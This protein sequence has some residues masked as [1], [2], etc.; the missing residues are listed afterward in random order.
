MPSIIP[1]LQSVY[2]QSINLQIEDQTYTFRFKF[3][4]KEKAWYLYLGLIG[5]TPRTK[6]KIVNGLD[7]LNSWQAYDDIPK[8][9]MYV[10]DNDLTYGRPGKDTFY[11]GGRFFLLLT[12]HNEDLTQ[13]LK[14]YVSLL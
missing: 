4:D 14:D 11:S 10:V 13:L 3:N 5:A 9:T 8:A 1:V 2:D 6:I 12:R 7:L